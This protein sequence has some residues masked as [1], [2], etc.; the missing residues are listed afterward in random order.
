MIPLKEVEKEI[1]KIKQRNKRVEAD[2]AWE[3]SLFR[4]A[5]IVIATYLIVVLWLWMIEAPRPWLN[6]AVPSGAFI[7]STLTIPLIKRWWIKNRYK[8]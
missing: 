2:K 5:V 1:N 6:A 4:R 3:I 8:R 7:L